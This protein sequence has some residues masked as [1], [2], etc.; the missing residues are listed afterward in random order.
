MNLT[1]KSSISANM[2]NIVMNQNYN[3][4]QLYNNFNKEKGFQKDKNETIG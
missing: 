1:K 3:I 2:Q 4:Y